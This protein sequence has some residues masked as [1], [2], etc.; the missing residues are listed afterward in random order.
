MLVVVLL[1]ASLAS[2]VGEAGPS[3]SGRD[4]ERGDDRVGRPSRQ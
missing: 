1:A 4:G 3:G 2:T